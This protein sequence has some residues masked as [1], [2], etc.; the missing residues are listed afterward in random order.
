VALRGHLLGVAESYDGG[1]QSTVAGA[2]VRTDRALDA[3]VF[4]TVTH[5]GT[6]STARLA[7]LV[8]DLDREDV[9]PVLLAGV[10]P[11]WFNLVDLPA[12]AERTGRPVLAVAFEDSPGLEPALREQFSGRALADRLAVYERLPERHPVDVDGRT[13]YLRAVG[14]PVDAAAD[15]LREHGHEGRPE[16][17]RVARL[18]ARAGATFRAEDVDGPDDAGT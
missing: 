17:L 8:A 10:A 14:C 4:S 9:G 1:S 16:P 6:D 5:G 7:D 12:L 13:L 18:A 3:L 2:V 11:A 15:R